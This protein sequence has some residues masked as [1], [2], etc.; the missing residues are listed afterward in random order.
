MTDALLQSINDSAITP[1]IELLGKRFDSL[2]AR[3]LLLAIALQESGGTHRVQLG[4]G[5]ARGLWQFEQ[6]GG[7]RG[8][9][10]HKAS[11]G[12][13]VRLCVDRKVTPQQAP[14]WEALAT[15]DVLAA[16]FARLLL[17]TD[18]RP[19][20]PMTNPQ[21]GWDYYFRLWRPGKPRPKDWPEN[22]KLARNFYGVKV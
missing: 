6:G 18:P 20:P 4:N 17:F 10:T 1:A 21:A 12:D 8:V 15:D 7:V 13:A 14:A 19:L 9:L 22:H 3:V 5:P 2:P 16:G 11:T